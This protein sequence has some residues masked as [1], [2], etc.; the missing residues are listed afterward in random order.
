MSRCHI[1]KSILSI[2]G[3]FMAA[4]RS[5]RAMADAK[6]VFRKHPKVARVVFLIVQIAPK[7][8]YWIIFNLLGAMDKPVFGVPGFHL[9]GWSE[10]NR[11][12]IHVES[13]TSIDSLPF[14]AVC[15]HRSFVANVSRIFSRFQFFFRESSDSRRV[16]PHYRDKYLIY[17]YASRLR[18]L[19]S[20]V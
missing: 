6:K 5:E 7:K 2:D 8:R 3:E 15:I 4:K 1:K 16:I 17:S 14:V 9:A 13:V 12:I 20:S 19:S 10:V 11:V 18:F